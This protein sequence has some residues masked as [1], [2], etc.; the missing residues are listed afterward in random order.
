M[1][2]MVRMANRMF[3]RSRMSNS[4]LSC[5]PFSSM[6]ISSNTPS[7]A[8]WVINTFIRQPPLLQ[9]WLWLWFNRQARKQCPAIP[10]YWRRIS[11]C[12]MGPGPPNTYNGCHE[13]NAV[14]V[15][16]EV[17]PQEGDHSC[18]FWILLFMVNS[19]VLL[20]AEPHGVFTP[21]A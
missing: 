12:R 10:G 16:L 11:I 15:F 1:I 3:F 20:N 6:L 14:G 19:V 4:N 5:Q 13:P 18:K 9:P 7:G 2:G 8:D 21:E 17:G